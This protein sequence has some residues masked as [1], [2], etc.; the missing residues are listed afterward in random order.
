MGQHTTCNPPFRHLAREIHLRPNNYR[1]KLARARD[2]RQSEEV[3]RGS[4]IKN[5]R[6]AHNARE[7]VKLA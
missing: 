4:S 1:E 3:Q 7:A 2:S 6:R 5:R